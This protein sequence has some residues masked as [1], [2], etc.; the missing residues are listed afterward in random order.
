MCEDILFRALA[1][2]TL[3]LLAACLVLVWR[4]SRRASVM[5]GVALSTIGVAALVTLWMILSGV[6][7]PTLR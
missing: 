1:A 3:S 5:I 6:C 4:P 2:T 7:G